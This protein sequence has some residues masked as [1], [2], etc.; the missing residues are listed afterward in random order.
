VWQANHK[1]RKTKNQNQKG[2][3]SWNDNIKKSDGGINFLDI[4]VEE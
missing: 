3:P 2:R 1:N 4:F